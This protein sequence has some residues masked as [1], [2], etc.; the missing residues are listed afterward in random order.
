MTEKIYLYKSDKPAKKFYIQFINPKSGREKKVYFGQAG[1]SDMTQHG[2]EL[3]RQRYLARHSG[4]GENYRDIHTPGA[5]SKF[6]LWNKPTLSAS[7]RDTNK[8]FG[9]QIIQKRN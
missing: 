3:R 2:D 9:V 4:M 6:L 1:A 8:R 7:I 5:L